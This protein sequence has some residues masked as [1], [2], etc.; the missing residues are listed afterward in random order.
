M[1]A[2]ASRIVTTGLLLVL[3]LVSGIW[4]SH[5]GKS[6][7]VAIFTAHK[8]VAL[9]T[10]IYAA[11]TF[12]YLRQGLDIRTVVIAAIGVTAVLFLSLFVSGALLSLGKPLPIVV[13]ITHRMVSVL[14]TISITATTYLLASERAASCLR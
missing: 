8:L 12:N 6:L 1:G 13:L 10:V 14:L 4:L 11:M 5:S 7:N 9:A 2:V 3:T